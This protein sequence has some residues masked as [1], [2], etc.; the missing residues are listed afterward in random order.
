MELL[1]TCRLPG[2]HL[3]WH[4]ILIMGT[5]CTQTE[6]FGL[7]LISCICRVR[8]GGASAGVCVCKEVLVL[9]CVCVGRCWYCA[10][11][12]VRVASPAVGGI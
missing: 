11:V 8:G 3:D 10:G 4:C 6:S 7:L 12:R 2:S 9:V 1:T 5:V